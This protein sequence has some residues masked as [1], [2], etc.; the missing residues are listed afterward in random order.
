MGS[1]HPIVTEKVD[2]ELLEEVR[3]IE[4]VLSVRKIWFKRK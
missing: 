1:I 3:D 2:D 4:K